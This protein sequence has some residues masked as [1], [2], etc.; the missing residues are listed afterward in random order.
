MT[1]PGSHSVPLAPKLGPA[2]GV[3][4]HFYVASRCTGYTN[5]FSNL[6]PAFSITCSDAVLLARAGDTVCFTQIGEAFP[7]QC[8]KAPIA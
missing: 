6:N 3:L 8:L 2:E 1:C 4:G 5:L 7:L